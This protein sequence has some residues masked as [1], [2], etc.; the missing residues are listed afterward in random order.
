LLSTNDKCPISVTPVT[1]KE[2][3]PVY[4]QQN[5]DACIIRISIE[6]DNG[7]MYKSILVGG[8]GSRALLSLAMFKPAALLVSRAPSRRAN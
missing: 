6:D 1:S 5:R 3:P 7:N 8:A 2:P 4:N